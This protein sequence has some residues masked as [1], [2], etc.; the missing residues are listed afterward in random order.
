MHDTAFVA[1]DTPRVE[2]HLAE[3][4]EVPWGLCFVAVGREHSILG[5]TCCFDL[6]PITKLHEAWEVDDSGR[7]VVGE[8]IH[9]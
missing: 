2:G 3:F 6:S 7:Q 1:P 9:V 8:R 4:A 5:I